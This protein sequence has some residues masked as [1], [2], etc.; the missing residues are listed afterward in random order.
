MLTLNTGRGGQRIRDLEETTGT[1]IKVLFIV[2]M[3][4]ARATYTVHVCTLHLN[5]KMS[6]DIGMG[7]RKGTAVSFVPTLFG[8][9]LG[10]PS[11]H[12]CSFCIMFFCDFG[13]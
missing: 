7:V 1:R 11:L 2:R 8:C 12:V 9:F 10:I 6:K 5:G 13:Q 3:V 4:L